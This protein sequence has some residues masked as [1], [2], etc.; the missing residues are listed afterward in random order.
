[1]T[2][3]HE[4]ETERLRLRLW[5]DE[6][7][8]PW[9]ELGSDV[10]VMEYFLST[11]SRKES[12]ESMARAR[13]HFDEHGYGLWAVEVK[14]GAPFI[15]FVGLAHV[16]FDAAFGPA[17]EIGW[18]L[19]FDAWGHGYA[20]EGAREALRFAFDTLGLGEVVSFTAEGNRRSSAVMERIGLHH[21]PPGDFDHPRIPDGHPIQRHVL[22]RISREGWAANR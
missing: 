11:V 22:Y 7:L 12:A 9:A 21:D 15:G 10:R 18:R 2:K 6:D 13:Q 8:D 17:V 20:S 19:A 4:L 1:M 5:R 16:Q 14:D 3:R